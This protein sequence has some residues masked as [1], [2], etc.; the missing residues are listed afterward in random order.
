MVIGIAKVRESGAKTRYG[1]VYLN[2]VHRNRDGRGDA[3]LELSQYGGCTGRTLETRRP[4]VANLDDA[5]SNFKKWGMTQPQQSK[6]ATDRRAMLSVPIF[7]FSAD[8]KRGMEDLPIIGILSVDCSTSLSET[9]WIENSD[10]EESEISGE[11]Y[12]TMTDP[13]AKVMRFRKYQK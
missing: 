7:A 9:N 1:S 4:T 6:V 11:T 5:K 10:G 13:L 3:D 12:R 8:E 2:R